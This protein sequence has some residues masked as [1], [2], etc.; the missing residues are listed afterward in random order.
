MLNQKWKTLK[1]HCQPN[2]LLDIGAGT[3]AFAS[4]AKSKGANVFGVEPSPKARE[5]AEQAL[6]KK[7]SESI[8]QVS[9]DDLDCITMWHVL[10][11]VPTLNKDLEKTQSLLK[12]DGLLVIAVPN[13]ESYDA[14]Y[15]GT[16]WAALDVPRH[17]YHFSKKSLVETVSKHGFQLLQLKNMPLD[18]FYVSLLSEKYTSKTESKF[19]AMKVALKSNLKGRKSKNQSSI[20]YVFK[21]GQ[22]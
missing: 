6:E 5:I 16:A 9:E 1:L 15:Y 3:G 11:H 12:D 19:N 8:H 14:K 2:R 17:L 21:K 18:S 10:E 22:F 13:I 7:L 20:I 4:F